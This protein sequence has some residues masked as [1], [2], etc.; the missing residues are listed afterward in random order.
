M[1]KEVNE[2]KDHTPGATAAEKNLCT[3][4]EEEKGGKC[5]GPGA[6]VGPEPG[7]FDLKSWSVRLDP[8]THPASTELRSPVKS[9][10]AV[11]HGSAIEWY[12]A[13]VGSSPPETISGVSDSYGVA[14]N[15]AS[16]THQL[17]ASELEAD[18]VVTFELISVPNVT[19]GLASE[20]HR[21]SAKPILRTP[22][23]NTSLNMRRI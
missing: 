11:D 23:P 18:N 1:G 20:I 4:E 6:Y 7:S 13:P 21:T 19:T 2:T 17:Y 10:L 22:T 5:G 14:V 12:K 16:P 3:E 15:S 9:G 8:P